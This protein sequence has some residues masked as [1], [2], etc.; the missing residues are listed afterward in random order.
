MIFTVNEIVR[1]TKG[2]LAQGDGLSK[3]RQVSIDSRRIGAGQ[4]FVAVQ[5]GRHDGHD[6]VAQAFRRGAVAAVV[7]RSNLGQISSK[8][9]LIMVDDTVRALG[10][11]AR[12]YRRRFHLPV[13]A[14]T[15]STGKSTTKEMIAY[16]LKGDYRVLNNPGTENNQFGVPLT[17]MKIRSHHQMLV[18]ELGTNRPGDIAWL[19]SICEPDVAVFTNVGESHLERLKS[20]GQVFQE[21]KTLIPATRADG[22]VIINKDDRFL[23]TLLRAKISQRV[24]TYGIQGT[25][26]FQ[27]G[28][29]RSRARDGWAFCVNNRY[30]MLIRS[31]AYH[32]IYNALAAVACA[33][34]FKV[35]Y[36]KI[37]DR[38]ARCS[39]M[40]GRQTVW[41]AG[42][43]FIIDDSYNANPV[44]FESALLTLRDFSC[45]GRRILVCADMLELG[46]QSRPLHTRCGLRAAQ[47]GVDAV[48]GYGPEAWHLI[49]AVRKARPK[50][51]AHHFRLRRDLNEHLFHYCQRGDVCLVKGSRAMAMD[52]TVTTL[53]HQLRSNKGR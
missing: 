30:P 11:I 6:Y 7:S 38:L 46:R 1:I 25:A 9:G 23:K 53:H 10:W 28:G 20:P 2:R 29:I 52:Q 8:R 14:I 26:D 40:H 5:G 19:A 31:N 51:T 13:V 41:K 3:I 39:Y 18:L 16:L 42:G 15:G 21:K 44:S 48:F 36:K 33:R 24:L 49:R 35:D 45:S 17:L 43:V 12:A 32:N 22:T 27:A 4:L 37:S 47:S 34:L 50:I